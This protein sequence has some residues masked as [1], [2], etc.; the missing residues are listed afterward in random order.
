MSKFAKKLSTKK[1]PFGPITKKSLFGPTSPSARRIPA[2]IGGESTGNIKRRVPAKPAKRPL[3]RKTLPG[4][5]LSTTG[6]D[7]GRKADRSKHL[8]TGGV[9]RPAM[10]VLQDIRRDMNALRVGYRKNLRAQLARVCQVADRLVSS[11]DE[12]QEFCRHR[13]WVDRE[14]KPISTGRSRSEVLRF[15]LIAAVGGTSRSSAQRASKFYNQLKPLYEAERG[16]GEILRLLQEHGITHAAKHVV[17]PGSKPG[18]K[19]QGASSTP[20]TRS[21]KAPSSST[22]VLKA[23]LTLR[24]EGHSL[25]SLPRDVDLVLVA[26]I[27]SLGD[28]QA[29]MTIMEARQARP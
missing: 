7:P 13:F 21:T 25:L 29:T 17:E 1:S 18:K 12:W 2:S 14:L 22:T 9:E 23:T 11:A 15:T 4:R 20:S 6:V 5:R 26:K 27:T 8:R 10:V 24:G 16:R 28:G 19:G 3:G